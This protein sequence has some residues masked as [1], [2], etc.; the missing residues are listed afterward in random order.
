MTVA[1]PAL[2]MAESIG[3]DVDIS[4]AL[5]EHESVVRAMAGLVVAA[6]TRAVWGAGN[7]PGPDRPESSREGLLVPPAGFEPA[8]PA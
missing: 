4:R 8:L 5:E 6:R 7:Q 3:A 2:S 1:A